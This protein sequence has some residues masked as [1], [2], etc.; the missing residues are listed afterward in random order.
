V[1][2]AMSCSAGWGEP[3]PVRGRVDF[4][5]SSTW[6][7]YMGWRVSR[8]IGHRKL[9]VDLKAL[10]WKRLIDAASGL[11]QRCEVCM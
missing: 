1:L 5:V 7:G 4:C 6:S 8:K 9:R 11:R 2:S 3:F 10:N